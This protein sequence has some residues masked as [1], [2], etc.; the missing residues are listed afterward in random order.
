[1]F[2]K[3]KA[4]CYNTHEAVNFI[5]YEEFPY[6]REY[7]KEFSNDNTGLIP[8]SVDIPPYHKQQKRDRIR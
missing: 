6:Y 3:L 1:M 7:K 8:T 5:E 4:N 2:S